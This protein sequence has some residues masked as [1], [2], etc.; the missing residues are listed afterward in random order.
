MKQLAGERAP[1]GVAA[2]EDAA[3]DVRTTACKQLGDLED[4]ARDEIAWRLSEERA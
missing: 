2:G 3:E 1:S 4:L